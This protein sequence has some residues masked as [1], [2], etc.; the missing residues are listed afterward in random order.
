VG[1]SGAAPI[2]IG[3]AIALVGLGA[4]GSDGGRARAP[5]PGEGTIAMP[6]RPVIVDPLP[7]GW[8]VR[9]VKTSPALPTEM[10]TVYLAPGST[11]EHGPALAI[12]A[13]GTEFGEGLCSREPEDSDVRFDPRSAYG[14]RYHD[15]NLISFDGERFAG[16]EEWGFVLGRDLDEPTVRR[17][18]KAARFPVDAPAHIL[19]SGLPP[20]FQ[21]HARAPVVPNAAFG[22]V[23]E[24]TAADG[25]GDGWLQIGTYD[26]DAA[27]DALARFWGATIA[28][29]TCDEGY[30]RSTASVG[31]TNVLLRGTAPRSVVDRVIAAL[32]PT[33]EEGLAAFAGSVAAAPASSFISGCDGADPVIDGTRDRVR[34]I[35][36][37]QRRADGG[38]LMCQA[39]VVDG[40]PEGVLASSVASGGAAPD[41]DRVNVLANGAGG[42]SVGSGQVIAGTVPLAARRV[43]ITDGHDTT[44]ATLVETE[45]TPGVRWFAGMLLSPSNVAPGIASLTVTAFDAAGAEIGRYRTG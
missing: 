20:G 11:L 18:A 39:F 22:Q 36:G 41:P 40:H 1:R 14:F 44:D 13:L 25:G 10:Q 35:I 26:G 17:A 45:A 6:R 33:D 5:I 23:I 34:W 29:M 7:S 27:S 30:S 2:A 9:E 3:L 32:Q 24:L 4:C 16:S 21:Q 15:G 43:V 42:L 38:G 37:I 31:E 19:A 28:E 8:S 12:A